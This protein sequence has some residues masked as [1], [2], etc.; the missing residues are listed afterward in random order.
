MSSKKYDS[1]YYSSDEEI[2]ISTKRKRK[3]LFLL[4]YLAVTQPQLFSKGRQANSKKSRNSAI[5]FIRRWNNSMFERQFRLDRIHF[6]RIVQELDLN[7]PINAE[8]ARRSYFA[9][10]NAVIKLL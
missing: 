10:S 3:R 6:Y 7:F 4:Q 1:E 2:F 5:E 8:M 9:P